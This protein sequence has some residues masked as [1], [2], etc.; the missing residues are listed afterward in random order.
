MFCVVFHD[1]SQNYGCFR[2]KQYYHNVA[3]IN[4]YV[5]MY[6]MLGQPSQIESTEMIEAGR[7]FNFYDR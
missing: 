2:E 7:P 6:D 3:D 1:L 5:S 4:S